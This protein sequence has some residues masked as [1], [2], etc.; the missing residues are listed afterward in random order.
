MQGA[1]CMWGFAQIPSKKTHSL[2]DCFGDALYGS[3]PGAGK[4]PRPASG[5]LGEAN[6]FRLS[7]PSSPGGS[8]GHPALKSLKTQRLQNPCATE[9]SMN[10][11]GVHRTAPRLPGSGGILDCLGGSQTCYRDVFEGRT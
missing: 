11:T 2:L 4:A 7:A 1:V 6:F 9:G 3:F 8:C 5:A 10:W